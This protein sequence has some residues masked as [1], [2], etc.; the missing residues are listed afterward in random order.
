MVE[1]MKLNYLTVTGTFTMS[2]CSTCPFSFKIKVAL[3]KREIHHI[4]LIFKVHCCAIGYVND[5]FHKE[6]SVF[7]KIYYPFLGA[8]YESSIMT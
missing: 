8:V 3:M 1:I 2:C 4:I 5:F 6:K 7:Y